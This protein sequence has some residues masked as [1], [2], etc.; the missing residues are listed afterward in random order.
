MTLKGHRDLGGRNY[1]LYEPKGHG[2][3]LGLLDIVYDPEK[4]QEH[5]RSP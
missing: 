3:L 5:Y 1:L 4:S 2:D